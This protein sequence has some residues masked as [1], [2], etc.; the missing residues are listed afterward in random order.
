VTESYFGSYGFVLV[1]LALLV[2]GVGV[3]LRWVW[4]PTTSKDSTMR[5]PS[6][7]GDVV[8][9]PRPVLSSEEA[10]LFNLIGLAVQDHFLVLGKLSVLQLIS[11]LDKDEDA[12]RAVMRNLQSVRLDIVLVHPGTLQAQIVI[13]FRQGKDGSAKVDERERLMETVLKAAGI[14]LVFL[15]LDR[16][17]S[18]VQLTE[19]LGLAQD[20]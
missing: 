9:T 3:L 8:V 11:F 15:A 12:R 2:A 14:Q 5:L 16:T 19:L 17:Y 6:D 10:T 1:W 13:K 20:E 7:S 18:V 4:H